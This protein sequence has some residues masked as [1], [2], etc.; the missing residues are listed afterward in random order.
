MSEII[1]TIITT[2]TQ[3]N[4]INPKSFDKEPQDTSFTYAIGLEFIGTAYRGWQR[5]QEVICIQQVVE[6]A[7]GYIANEP[8][9][10]VA[11]GRTDAG[12]HAGNMVAH[13]QT[14]AKRPLYGWFRGINS[15]LPNDITLRWIQPMPTEF[16]ARFSAIARR[17]RYVTLCQPYPPA[18]LYGQ[19]T[20]LTKQLDIT[21]MQK[22]TDCLV[23]QHDFS[24]FRAAAC[25]SRQ[26]VR[27]VSHAK[28]FCH[29]AFIVFD[30]QADGF[31]HHMVRNLM[32]A[33][34]AI[35]QG[36]LPTDAIETLI[37]AK[38]RTQAPATAAADGLYF[39]DAIYPPHLQQHLPNMDKTPV[40]LGLPQ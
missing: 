29:G 1:T 8:I 2:Q 10:V 37:T 28:L 16:H 38:D 25:Q 24:S 14:R 23:G 9:E 32:G 4:N 19:V 13:F 15:L 17:Y 39:I 27:C 36:E 6:E 40:W 12:V 26:P 31:L 18:L 35:G 30:I 21:A 11:S 20:H 3:Q 33:L 22:A 34:F 7:I 5:Q